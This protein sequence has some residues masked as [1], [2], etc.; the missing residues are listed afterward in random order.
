MEISSNYDSFIKRIS[1]INLYLIVTSLSLIFLA[2]ISVI[3]LASN[4]LYSSI[5]IFSCS[6]VFGINYSI[7]SNVKKKVIV[8][9][10]KLF[11]IDIEDGFSELKNTISMYKSGE[12][13]KIEA[14]FTNKKHRR[15]RGFDEKGPTGGIL[16]SP[17]DKN[18]QRIDAMKND[19]YQ[20]ITEDITAGQA[21]IREA[22]EKYAKIS[23]ERWKNAEAKDSDLIEAGVERLGDLLRTD[24]FEKNA[25]DGAIK[26]LYDEED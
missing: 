18:N 14:S 10:A 25:K 19:D 23:E 11:E 8:D 26:E 4:L 24:W 13:E 5:I 20:E 15:S 22:D 9:F 7:T 17:L 6:A 21:L 16:I 1:R 12:F 3:F 2:I